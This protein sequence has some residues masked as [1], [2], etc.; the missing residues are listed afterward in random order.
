MPE[1]LRIHPGDPQ[2]RHLD[3]AVE[4]LRAGGVIIY[5]TDTVYGIGCDVGRADAVERVARIKGRDPDKPFSFVCSDLSGISR[6]ARMSDPAFRLIRR[7]L[8][9]PYT[10]VLRGTREVPRLLRTKRKT[11]GIRVPDHPVPLALVARLGRPILSTSAN[12]GGEE[13][14]VDPEDRDSPVVRS[15]DLVLSVG[16]LPVLPSTVV[17]LVDDVPVVLREGAG[18]LSLF[19]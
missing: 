6:Y 11:V 19:A 10:F 14:I 3:R 15:V 16:P 17:S 9:G 18:D 12:R 7:C 2:P 1:I 5:P 4:R 13:V 8:P